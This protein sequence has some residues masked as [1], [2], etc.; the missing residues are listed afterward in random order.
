M[1]EQLLF[2]AVDSA[3]LQLHSVQGLTSMCFVLLQHLV[4]LTMMMMVT[5]DMIAVE[6]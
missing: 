5:I 6:Q 2:D 3:Y 4:T 1:E